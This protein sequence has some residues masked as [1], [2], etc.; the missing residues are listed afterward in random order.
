MFSRLSK[1]KK[2]VLVTF[3][4]AFVLTLG[5][6]IGYLTNHVFSENAK[7]EAFTDEIFKNEVS[8]SSLTLHYSLA[9]PEKQGIIRPKA[10]LGLM[11][12]D[13]RQSKEL[14]QTYEN[15]LKSFH[16]AKLSPENQLTLDMLLLYYHT[17][18]SPGNNHLLEEP[19]GPSLGIQAQLPI[20]LAEYAFYEEQDITD[21]L[22]LLS[23]VKP[24]FDSLIAFEQKNLPPD[25]L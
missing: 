11:E 18:N 10:T 22:N 8:G 25:F 17:Q 7:F 13:N 16:Y 9:H 2:V 15:T 6:S 20:L 23:S 19:L 12:T 3:L 21:Y 1:S 24:Y 4:C 14:S 5:I